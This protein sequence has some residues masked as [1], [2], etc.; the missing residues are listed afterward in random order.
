M[1]LAE[2]Q[3]MLQN[4]SEAFKSPHSGACVPWKT[5]QASYPGTG[6]YQYLPGGHLGNKP[7]NNPQKAA[8]QEHPLWVLLGFAF[9]CQF[10]LL[11]PK[12]LACR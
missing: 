10:L 4:P 8:E 1:N 2:N 5:N 3:L 6:T 9:T 11:P 7:L 12:C